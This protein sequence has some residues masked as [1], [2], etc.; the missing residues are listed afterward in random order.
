M[1]PKIFCFFSI[2]VVF[3]FIK[4]NTAFA[5]AYKIKIKNFNS[6]E[7]QETYCVS[8]KKVCVATLD[9]SYIKDQ[10]E[11]QIDVLVFIHDQAADIRFKADGVL[12]STARQGW[13]SFYERIE[14]FSGEPQILKLYLPNSTIASDQRYP[15]P[16][17]I[18]SPNEFL[19]AISIDLEIISAKQEE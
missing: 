9:F 2:L 4:A 3:A 17:V 11:E 5:D 14:N 12:L 16:L 10:R 19:T 15:V 8:D 18:R 7:T 1:R 6:Y 13:D